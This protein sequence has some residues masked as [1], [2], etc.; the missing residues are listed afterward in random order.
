[1]SL[2]NNFYYRTNTQNNM[3]V[4][5]YNYQPQQNY[6]YNNGTYNNVNRMIYI[7]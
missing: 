6:Y 3:N 2:Y 4:N 7:I 5:G 1:M